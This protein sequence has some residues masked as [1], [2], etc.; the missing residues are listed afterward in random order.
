MTLR[1]NYYEQLLRPKARARSPSSSLLICPVS[2]YE[3][4]MAGSLSSGYATPE[5]LLRVPGESPML[6]TPTIL[7]LPAGCPTFQSCSL[8][9]GFFIDW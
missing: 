9:I 1:L 8:S 6:L 7:S 2:F 3:Y 4:H 5:L